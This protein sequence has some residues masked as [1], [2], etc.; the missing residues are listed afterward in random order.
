MADARHHDEPAV[1]HRGR[2]GPEIGRSNPAVLLAPN[3]RCGF[4]ILD[5]WRA[6][7]PFSPSRLRLN[8]VPSQMLSE[9]LNVASRM[10]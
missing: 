8:G 10:H 2:H 5:M 9:T 1:R 3:I 7:S 6:S 4:L